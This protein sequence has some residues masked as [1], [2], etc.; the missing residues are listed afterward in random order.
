MNAT[1]AGLLCVSCTSISDESRQQTV[2]CVDFEDRIDLI[3]DRAVCFAG[4]KVFQR[5][6]HEINSHSRNQGRND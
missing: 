5:P 3:N 6:K 2:V 4:V 1:A